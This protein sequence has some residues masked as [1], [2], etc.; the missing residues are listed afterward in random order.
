MNLD[1]RELNIQISV[2]NSNTKINNFPM[3][4]FKKHFLLATATNTLHFETSI[5]CQ[6]NKDM[7]WIA[8]SPMAVF[9]LAKKMSSIKA[10]KHRQLN[11]SAKDG[12]CW[13]NHVFCDSGLSRG[14]SPREIWPHSSPLKKFMVGRFSYIL[15][16]WWNDL[17]F[18]ANMSIFLGGGVQIMPLVLPPWH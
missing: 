1:S 7:P 15:L 11:L 12:G 13:K 8:R 18:L 2:T 5:Y 6:S 3:F 10:L 17:S 9:R 4:K 16:S 14:S